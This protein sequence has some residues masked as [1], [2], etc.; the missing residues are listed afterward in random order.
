[1]INRGCPE[2]NREQGEVNTARVVAS[3]DVNPGVKSR[4][5]LVQGG[6][7]LVFIFLKRRGGAPS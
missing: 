5:L 4:A 7:I 2:V 6:V 1:M 3:T